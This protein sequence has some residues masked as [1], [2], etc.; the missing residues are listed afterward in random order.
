MSF[1]YELR[2]LTPFS[3]RIAL[4]PHQCEQFFL[5]EQAT[6]PADPIDFST[7]F[8]SQDDAYPMDITSAIPPAGAKGIELSHTGGEYELYS[9]LSSMLTMTRPEL[10]LFLYLMTACAEP[11]FRKH[12]DHH[13][14]TNRIV[15]MAQAWVSQYQDLTDTYLQYMEEPALDVSD[16]E[17]EQFTI[18]VIDIFGPSFCCRV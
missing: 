2:W 12:Y 14:W 11:L 13:D 10:Y 6:Q 8:S 7:D 9:E 16:D 18:E 3:T 15:E 4:D 1:C 17:A 5:A